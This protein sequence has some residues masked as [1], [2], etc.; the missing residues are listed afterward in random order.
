MPCRYA[1]LPLIFRDVSR[2][3]IDAAD[4]MRWRFTYGMPELMPFFAAMFDDAAC[5]P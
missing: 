5:S 4:Y 2:L 1:T 3:L